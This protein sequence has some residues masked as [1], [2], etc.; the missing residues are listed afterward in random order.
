MRKTATL[1]ARGLVALGIVGALAAAA[2]AQAQKLLAPVDPAQAQT[3]HVVADLWLRQISNDQNLDGDH[4][5]YYV[6]VYRK[7]G[8]QGEEHR[9][10]GPRPVG[11]WRLVNDTGVGPIIAD[12]LVQAHLRGD[13][14]YVIRITHGDGNAPL[15]DNPAIEFALDAGN[16]VIAIVPEALQCSG[17]PDRQ[18]GIDLKTPDHTRLWITVE[19]PGLSEPLTGTC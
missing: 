13:T 16:H 2:P 11:E 9:I 8:P 6:T 15:P 7:Q 19:R 4:T 5:T 1:A 3:R 18:P 14:R 12:R 17:T 10:V